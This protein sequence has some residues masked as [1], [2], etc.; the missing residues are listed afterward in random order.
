MARNSK[1]PLQLKGGKQLGMIE[2]HLKMRVNALQGLGKRKAGKLSKN[3]FFS[4]E[5]IQINSEAFITKETRAKFHRLYHHM[6]DSRRCYECNKVYDTEIQN[7]QLRIHAWAHYIA[8]TCKLCVFCTSRPGHLTQHRRAKHPD[9]KGS[10]TVKVDPANWKIARDVVALPAHCPPLPIKVERSHRPVKKAAKK[11]PRDH[12]GIQRKLKRQQ[13][14]A[15]HATVSVH[16]SLRTRRA[17][18]PS[19]V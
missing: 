9:Y 13:Q 19:P 4:Q 15:P 18:S 2:A 7:K 14:R 1:F 8:T 17:P 10:V 11:T 5:K 3:F 12:G 16:R 6:K